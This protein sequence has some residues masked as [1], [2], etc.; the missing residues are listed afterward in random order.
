[1]NSSSNIRCGISSA[2]FYPLKLEQAVK[3]LAEHGVKHIEIFINTFSEIQSPIADEIASIVKS[4]NQEVAA[5]HPFTSA[6]E[7]FMLF[8]GYERR[9]NDAI[10]FH[11]RYFEFM[12]RLGAKIFVLHG[13]KTQSVVE[14]EDYFERFALLRDT[15]KSFGVTVAHENVSRCK[16]GSIPFLKNMISYLDND[17]SLV[18]DN[19]QAFR[20]GYTEQEFI[21][22]LG[23]NIAHM[24]ISDRGEVGDCLPI[25]AGE[26]D[27]A[28]II[29]YMKKYGFNGAI[30]VELY[31]CGDEYIKDI[32]Q[33]IDNLRSAI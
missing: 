13:A 15:G 22:E 10:E 1:M 23:T 2:C 17:V 29:T 6:F 5:I 24:H 16:G 27:I 20:A 9:F 18:F 19:K 8:T 21:R 33:S 14:D 32:Y 4:S 11:K 25:G 26:L 3:N 28:E 12:N 31:R 30:M 7:P